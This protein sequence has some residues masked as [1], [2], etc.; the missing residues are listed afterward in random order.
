MIRLIVATDPTGLMGVTVKHTEDGSPPVGEG[1]YPPPEGG[2][3]RNWIVKDKMPW[4][5]KQDLR[6]F[7][8]VTMGGVLI[9]GKMT[10][11]SL[12]GK[13]P[14]RDHVILTRN[15]YGAWT[16]VDGD[17]APDGCVSANSLEEALEYCN[18][19]DVWITGGRQI[20]D[21]ALKA[22]VVEEVDH[23]FV[24]EVDLSTIEHLV[25]TTMFDLSVL[26]DYE[27]VGEEVNPLDERLT[28]RRYRCPI[29]TFS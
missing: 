7:K 28:H 26:D 5:Y 25:K 6:R 9:M 13:L 27:L 21:L 23:T 22:G 1:G 11:V 3:R 15:P 12:P 24:P 4:H 8:K 14:G 2:V 18:G 10:W 19:M 17:H 29:P 16:G 20:Y